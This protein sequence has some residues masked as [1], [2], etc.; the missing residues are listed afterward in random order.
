MMKKFWAFVLLS[1]TIVFGANENIISIVED[2]RLNGEAN[3]VAKLEKVLQSKNYWLEYLANKNIDYGFYESVEHILVCD[4]SKPELAL[5]SNNANYEIK[6]I[7]TVDAIVGKMKGD[8]QK[9]NDLRTPVGTYDL[10]QRLDTVDQFYGPLAFVTSYPNLYD[11]LIGKDGHGI[12]IHGLPINKKRDD[13]KN[14]KGCIA[15]DNDNLI[16]LSKSINYN[17]SI[18][19]ISENELKKVTKDEL[20]IIMAQVYKWREAWKVADL[21]KYL[22]FYDR[23][24]IRFDGKGFSAFADMKK[25]IF[26]D[27]SVKSITFWNFSIAPYPTTD[28][29]RMFRVKFDEN[30]KSKSHSFKGRKELY[31]RIV[32]DKIKILAEQ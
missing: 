22:S 25:S 28:K 1:S 11:D 24:F 7:G 15:I 3:L 12:W 10:T 26:Q 30:Y 19:I 13:E 14:T 27:K 23:E 21:E 6:H 32:D 17:K 9:E 4:K 16:K 8:K 18:L 31:V 29:T 20:A 2:Y 5:F